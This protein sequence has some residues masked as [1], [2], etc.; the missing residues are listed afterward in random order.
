MSRTRTVLRAEAL[1]DRLAPAAAGPPAPTSGTAGIVTIPASPPNRLVGLP[2]GG[3]VIL[4]YDGPTP[5]LR[6]YAADGTADPNYG[7]G[8]KAVIG[9]IN[10]GVLP[11]N[12]L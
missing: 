1:E 6:H 3:Y 2:D 5:V 10:T 12:A 4:S 11:T 7:T 9:A 8:G